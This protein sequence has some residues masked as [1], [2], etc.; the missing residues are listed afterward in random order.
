[1][2]VGHLRVASC[3]LSRSLP[4][5]GRLD[6][7]APLWSVHPPLQ[8][9]LG[10]G[11]RGANGFP[12]QGSRKSATMA[13]G[14]LLET[15]AARWAVTAA[16]S[17]RWH[18][19]GSAGAL[20]R[21]RERRT[22]STAVPNP[23]TG[24]RPRPISTPTRACGAFSPAARCLRPWLRDPRRHRRHCP[25]DLRRIAHGGVQQLSGLQ[26]GGAVDLDTGGQCV[27]QGEIS[28]GELGSPA[29]R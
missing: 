13:A 12:I 23:G 9:A 2:T 8:P 17:S 19:R 18:R 29:P 1:M 3:E 10:P 4:W 21:L 20:C 28:H 5:P 26:A 25:S 14:G 24:A 15:A 7:L 22:A 27:Q 6:R 16:R 11:H